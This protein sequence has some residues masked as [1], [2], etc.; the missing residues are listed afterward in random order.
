MP[1]R[2]GVILLKIAAINSFFNRQNPFPFDQPRFVNIS[3]IY[4]KS[5]IL[6]PRID[7]I[8]HMLPPL[9]KLVYRFH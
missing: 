5:E 8:A 6:I 4:N 2:D 1:N 9:P 3:G 7:I